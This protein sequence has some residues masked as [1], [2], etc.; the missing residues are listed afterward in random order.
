MTLLDCAERQERGL[1]KEH[2]TFSGRRIERKFAGLDATLNGCSNSHV[3]AEGFDMEV[4]SWTVK[5]S[6]KYC[7]GICSQLPCPNL[8]KL[9]KTFYH[10]IAD[11]VEDARHACQRSKQ[12]KHQASLACPMGIVAFPANVCCLLTYDTSILE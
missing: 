4:D 5:Q 10:V 7:K 3:P 1:M 12:V 6:I 2:A 9:H 8:R 11:R